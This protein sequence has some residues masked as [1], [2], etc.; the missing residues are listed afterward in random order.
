[1]PAPAHH[2]VL[3][4]WQLNGIVSL[5][6]GYP[7][8][9]SL[10]TPNWSRSGNI[11]GTAEDRPSVKPGTDPKKII[12]GNPDHWFDTSAFF[13]PPLGTTPRNFPWTWFRKSTCRSS[14]TRR[15]GSTLLQ[16]R[17]EVFNVLNRANFAVPTRAVPAAALRTGPAAIGTRVTRIYQLVTA[18][19]ARGQALF[20]GAPDGDKARSTSGAGRRRRL[21]R[22]FQ[23]P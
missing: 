20:R 10:A 3:S 11:Q 15:C 7:F 13:A 17:L 9:P 16:L 21:I 22:R 19:S 6:S 8:T 12:T 14:R 4:G 5:R 23:R 18:D 1:V 2:A